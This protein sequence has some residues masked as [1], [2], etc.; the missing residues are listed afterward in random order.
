[1]KAARILALSRHSE[2]KQ[3]VRERVEKITTLDRL[4][5]YGKAAAFEVK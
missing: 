2:A 4:P 5:Y 3:V 1:V